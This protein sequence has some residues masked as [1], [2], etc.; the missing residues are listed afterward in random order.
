MGQVEKKSKEKKKKV[1]KK[2]EAKA[3][4]MGGD[5]TLDSI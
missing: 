5:Q 4:P 3:T 1:K 2:E